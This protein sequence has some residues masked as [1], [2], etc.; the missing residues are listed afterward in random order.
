MEL[1]FS[2]MLSRVD[3]LRLKLNFYDAC[4]NGVLGWLDY[5]A[6]CRRG[7]PILGRSRNYRLDFFIYK[8]C[9]HYSGPN[10]SVFE[11]WRLLCKITVV[12][13]III[14]ILIIFVNHRSLNMK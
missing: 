8:L 3:N 1:N 11:L 2:L 12:N 7:P 6:I 10:S 13:E 5:Y 4:G 14:L 9:I